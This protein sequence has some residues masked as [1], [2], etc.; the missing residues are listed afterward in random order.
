MKR[1]VFALFLLGSTSVVFADNNST[2]APVYEVNLI[3]DAA[4]TPTIDGIASLGEWDAANVAGDWVALSTGNVDA[5]NLEFRMLWD[6][7]NLYIMGQTNY[8]GFR[9]PTDENEDP[10]TDGSNYTHHIFLD[11]NRDMEDFSARTDETS[12]AYRVSWSMS[13]GFTS[14]MPSEDPTQAL[15][16][17]IDESGAF[18]NFYIPGFQLEANVNS[19]SGNTGKW[20]RP[21]DGPNVNYR[22]DSHPGIIFAQNAENTDLNETGVGGG[23]FEMAIAWSELDATNPER[24]LTQDDINEAQE[25][26]TP[27]LGA[28][29]DPDPRFADPESP[30]FLE[31]GLYAVDGPMEDEIWA[32][33]IG[34]I[35][36]DANN[37]S[38]SWSNPMGGDAERASLESWGSSGF[39]RIQFIGAATSPLDC[40]GD[41]AL[42]A[43]D[44]TCVTFETRDETLAALNILPADFDGDGTVAF[45]DFLKLATNFGKMEATYADGDANLNGTVDFFDFLTL[46]QNFGSPRPVSDVAAVPEPS[47]F[48]MLFIGA[49]VLFR[50]RRR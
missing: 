38:P 3:T 48:G 50:R 36:N 19:T 2:E 40:N 34:A 22:D 18:L 26:E 25:N 10:N 32:F 16:D 8:A 29:G 20:A 4:M 17:V 31:N 45:L 47:S 37:S 33:E 41:G 1:L 6:A 43:G 42:D 14:R 49:L 28:V 46:A 21:D 9:P 39:G 12:D 35:T 30:L 23:I 13:Q 24:V 7:S 15:R 44:L 5:H 11:P 27:E